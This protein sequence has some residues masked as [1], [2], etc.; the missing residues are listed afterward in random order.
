MEEIDGEREQDYVKESRR[1][2]KIL[3]EKD[4]MKIT[5]EICLKGQI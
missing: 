1:D 5:N 2:K 3:R 4:K